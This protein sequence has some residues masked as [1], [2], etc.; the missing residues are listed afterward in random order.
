MYNKG[1]EMA[2]SKKEMTFK[3][4]STE[5]VYDLWYFYMP[6][7]N[8][9]ITKN[10][11]ICWNSPTKSWVFKISLTLLQKC[12]FEDGNKRPKSL[13]YFGIFWIVVLFCVDV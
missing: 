1:G 9:H 8:R 6:S 11:L 12:I 7:H 5:L 2:K 13:N 4:I 10:Y 3:N